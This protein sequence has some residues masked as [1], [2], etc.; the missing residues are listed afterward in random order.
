[1][2][3]ERSTNKRARGKDRESGEVL[4][5]RDDLQDK[6]STHKLTVGNDAGPCHRGQT[7]TQA[8]NLRAKKERLQ[9]KVEA[10]GN[11]GSGQQE[12]TRWQSQQ[13]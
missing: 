1:M 12:H 9:D 5:K 11:T 8:E 4:P 2:C 13:R 10:E 3:G 7:E 6:N